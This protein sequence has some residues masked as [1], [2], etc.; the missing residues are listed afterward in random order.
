MVG[1]TSY[2][3]GG[4]AVDDVCSGASHVIASGGGF[5]YAVLSASS[6]DG[7]QQISVAMIPPPREIM[8]ADAPF[9]PEMED[10]VWSTARNLCSSPKEAVK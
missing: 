2:V 10:A 8:S 1:D 4:I 7:R 3:L 5:P 6:L 9:I